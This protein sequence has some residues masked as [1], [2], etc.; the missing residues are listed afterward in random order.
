M[1]GCEVDRL[2][3]NPLKSN[4]FSTRFVRPG[5]IPY[6]F[7]PAESR[8]FDVDESNR[9]LDRLW[10][11]FEESGSLGQIVGPHGSGKSTLLASLLMRWATA[12]KTVRHFVLHD[13]QRRLPV[14]IG[15]LDREKPVDLI[16]VDGFEQLGA[17]ERLRLKRFCRRR[18]IGLL[19]TTHRSIGLP[20]LFRTSTSPELV[21]TL[22]AE[23]F[24]RVSAGEAT[25]QS[26]LDQEGPLFT[27]EQVDS[28]YT[29]HDRN[30]RETFFALYDLFESHR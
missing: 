5:A 18:E 19:V 22:V 20:E 14:R 29:R 1:S 28:C 4:P 2:K 11:R 15:R 24:D 25:G 27:P 16:V 30:V 17:L 26:G 13:R 8:P 23:L 6:C 7:D 10:T 21:R 9:Q 12:G 3:S